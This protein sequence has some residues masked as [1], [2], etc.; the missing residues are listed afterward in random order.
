MPGRKGA[1]PIGIVHQ[2]DHR[3]AQERCLQP[4]HPCGSFRHL[5]YPEK[6]GR[7]R[8]ARNKP[9]DWRQGQLHGDIFS[10]DR[11]FAS[12]SLSGKAAPWLSVALRRSP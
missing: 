12:A 9:S 3:P 11:G 5:F 1:L 8:W 2:P 7:P 10:V 4:H 6:S